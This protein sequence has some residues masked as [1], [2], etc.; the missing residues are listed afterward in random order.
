MN[1]HDRGEQLI[2]ENVERAQ[3]TR[4]VAAA[5]VEMERSVGLL[6]WHLNRTIDYE[7]RHELAQYL[8]NLRRA[9][10]KVEDDL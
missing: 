1:Q 10:R 8:D 9:V 5:L 3:Q 6:A 2:A 7:A 4:N